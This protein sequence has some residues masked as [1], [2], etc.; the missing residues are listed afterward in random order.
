MRRVYSTARL[1]MDDTMMVEAHGTGTAA[2]DPIEAAAIARCFA[3]TRRGKTP[4]YVGAMK[5]GLGH[6]EG[7]AGIAGIIK[8]VLILENAIIPPNVNFEK[9]NP[10]IP[11]QKWN[12]QFPLAATPVPT[13]NLRRI[14]V[15][16]FGVGG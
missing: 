6:L 3:P 13:S 1:T 8:A 11:V 4:L 16:S 7:A 12:L 9:P 14:S 15:N 5:S 2:G 10:K